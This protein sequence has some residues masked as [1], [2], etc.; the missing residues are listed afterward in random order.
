MLFSQQSW[1]GQIGTWIF[2]G[3]LILFYPKYMLYKM[4]EDMDSV[5]KKLEGYTREGVDLVLKVS[6]EKGNPSIDPQAIVERTIE[7][8]VIPPVSLD[9]MGILKKI[10]HILDNAEDKF[11]DV[12][13][14]I[15]PE[16]DDVWNGNIK[17]LLKGT[18]GL[19]MIAK[20]VRHYVEF[21][22]KTGNLQI[23]MIMQMNMPLIKKIAKA[24]RDGV[25][26][27]SKGE[28]IGD[29]VGPL[30][31]AS[32]ITGEV[33][34]IAR[35][36]VAFNG[37]VSNRKIFVIK[38]NGP[39]ANLGKFGDAVK[40]I[41]E[42]EKIDK[43]ITID[44]SLK[45]EGEETGKV[46][47]GLGAA[48]GDPGPEKAKMEEIA[49]RLGI[50]LEAI[51]IKMSIEEAISPLTDKITASVEKTIDLIKIKIEEVKEGGKVLVVGVG[52]TCG[53]GNSLEVVKDMK[54]KEYEEEEEEK[55]FWDAVIRTLAKKMQEKDEIREALR[56]EEKKAKKEKR[57]KAEEET[58]KRAEEEKA[59]KE[60][61]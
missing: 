21:V 20:I 57:K 5:A 14:Q 18:I 7:F 16:S 22:R 2:F 11:D 3:I 34:P 17:S 37:E 40:K 45:L 51:V 12:T 31:A 48:I 9:P 52:N 38:A 46:S 35:D 26:A 43:I 50:P 13:K 60:K 44:A 39:G 29:S 33:T 23:A 6:K 1:M 36:I 24:Q 56:E 15:A 59:K 49:L 28:P 8:F 10:E 4:I 19:N 55:G 25:E 47:E 61:K 27:I 30:V 42:E 32:M 53:I 54:F 41:G 58:K